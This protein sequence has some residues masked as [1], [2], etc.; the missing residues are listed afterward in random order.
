MLSAC[1]I[2]TSVTRK[3]AFPTI[4]RSP[5]WCIGTVYSSFVRPSSV[6][7]TSPDVPS[8]TSF[9]AEY[10]LTDENAVTCS[11]RTDS[12]RSC[13]LASL[14]GAS[15]ADWVVNICPAVL[16][17]PDVVGKLTSSAML[18]E[19]MFL[20]EVLPATVEVAAPASAGEFCGSTPRSKSRCAAET[21]KYTLVTISFRVSFWMCMICARCEWQTTTC[22]AFLAFSTSEARFT[23]MPRKVTHWRETMAFAGVVGCE[24][25]SAPVEAAEVGAASPRGPV[26]T[27]IVGSGFANMLNAWTPS[28]PEGPGVG[29][30][31]SVCC[32]C[33]CCCAWSREARRACIGSV[34]M[35]A[36]ST[37][38]PAPVPVVLK[39]LLA[40]YPA[41]AAAVVVLLYRMFV[42]SVMSS[43]SFSAR[44][45]SA[46]HCFAALPLM[47]S[48][49]AVSG[50]SLWGC[51]CGGPL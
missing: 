20:F 48:T 36:S 49:S 38:P 22:P 8:E 5:A 39:P 32:G 25:C 40:T 41:G 16:V 35:M 28:K 50:I 7:G 19:L 27:A 29:M 9:S 42:L 15:S 51:D 17:L 1:F 11:A 2:G 23:F 34:A 4:F 24:S 45:A 44:S 37:R 21:S 46:A 6:T 13:A 47:S 10:S 26:V 33:C 12:W 14:Y 43:R 3:H 30:M 31:E 18:A